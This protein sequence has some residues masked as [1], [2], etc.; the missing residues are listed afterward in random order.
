M[1]EAHYYF[2]SGV[3][4]N[5]FAFKLYLDVS[6]TVSTQDLRAQYAKN[7]SLCITYIQQCFYTAVSDVGVSSQSA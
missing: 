5:T 7:D 3:Y 1:L 4:L 2:L 6:G